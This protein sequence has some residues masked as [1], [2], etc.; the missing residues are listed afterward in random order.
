MRSSKASC[1]VSSDGHPLW[2]RT[3]RLT[4]RPA[5]GSEVHALVEYAEKLG[6]D[7][8]EEGEIIL[9]LVPIDTPDEFDETQDG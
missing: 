1:A 4:I 6:F 3:D 9:Y 5:T 2:N 7:D 8:E